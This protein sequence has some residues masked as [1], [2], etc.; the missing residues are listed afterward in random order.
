MGIK[1]NVSQLCENGNEI[2]TGAIHLRTTM[3][4]NGR[5]IGRKCDVNG[6]KNDDN[7]YADED[8]Q[9]QSSSVSM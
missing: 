4:C 7:F 5:S 8:Y 6:G 2:K 3:W 1:Y 9:Y